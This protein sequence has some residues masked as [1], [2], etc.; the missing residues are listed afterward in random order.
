M[1][2]V[3]VVCVVQSGTP[4]HPS[5]H[6]ATQQNIVASMGSSEVTSWQRCFRFGQKPA[7]HLHNGGNGRQG[8]LPSD[9]D[10]GGG[11]MTN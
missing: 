11:Q 1:V 5:Q 2:C 3:C 8:R 10:T 4:G 7:E 9:D 6:L